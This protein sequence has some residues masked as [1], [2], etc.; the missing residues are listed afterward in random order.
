N[1]IQRKPRDNESIIKA[2]YFTNFRYQLQDNIRA[3]YSLGDRVNV[4]D[5]G[6]VDAVH[7]LEKSEDED[8][9]YLN[10]LWVWTLGM[11]LSHDNDNK[12]S[13]NE[14]IKKQKVNDLVIDY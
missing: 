5:E 4:L 12:K 7:D 2:R 10:I 3:H 1:G 8:T 13:L 9:G 6:F 11:L 14:I